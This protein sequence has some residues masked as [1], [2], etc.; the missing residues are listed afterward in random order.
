MDLLVESRAAAPDKLLVY[1][2][3]CSLA[4]PGRLDT[5]YVMH[6]IEVER[7][8][9]TSGRPHLTLRLPVVIGNNNLAT[10]LPF[11][12]RDRILNGQVLDIWKNA[13]RYPIDVDDA[14]RIS[15]CI[16]DD[17]R[18]RDRR[19][20]VALRPYRVPEIVDMMEAHLGRRGIKKM[21]ERGSDY[22]L[23]L[24]VA[25][26]L[27]D[28]I[29]IDRDEQYLMRVIAKYFAPKEAGSS[30]EFGFETTGRK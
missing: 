29:G 20:D 21:L 13:I 23:D 14:V 26:S 7:F 17:Q 18:M 1:F 8:L 6:K 5:P 12:I 27:A 9:A 22:A 10:T 15:S 16:I 28:L 24:T 4:D 30:S 25:H 3:S 19:V 2:S 11:Y